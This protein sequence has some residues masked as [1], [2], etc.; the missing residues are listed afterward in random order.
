M[1]WKLGGWGFQ[2]W[3]Q[4]LGVRVHHES[5]LV[6]LSPTDS[7]S[8]ADSFSGPVFWMGPKSSGWLRI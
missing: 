6:T 4:D 1:K 5:V 2:G 7:D 8:I 3:I